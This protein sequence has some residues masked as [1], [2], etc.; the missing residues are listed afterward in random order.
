MIELREISLS[1][2]NRKVLDGFSCGFYKGLNWL[3]G[4]SGSGKSSI[5]KMILGDLKPDKGEVAVPDGLSFA[6]AG[7]DPSLLYD[8]DFQTNLRKFASLS[9]LP[10]RLQRLAKDFDA[11]KLFNTRIYR[12]SG[13]ERK[14]LELL[15]ALAKP[16]DLYIL[17]EPFSSLDRSSK[18]ALAAYLTETKGQRNYL[19]VNHDSDTPLPYDHK[20]AI[21]NGKAEAPAAG[22]P[23]E[24]EV[25]GVKAKVSLWD[26]LRHLLFEARA[27]TALEAVMFLLSLLSLVTCLGFIPPNEDQANRIGLNASPFPMTLFDGNQDEV[28]FE[29][30]MA[31]YDAADLVYLPFMSY[32]AENDYLSELN[33]GLLA[34]DEAPFALFQ[35]ENSQ[36]FHIHPDYSYSKNDEVIAGQFA[37]LTPESPVLARLKDYDYFSFIW[38]GGDQALFL[39]PKSELPYVAASFLNG[40]FHYQD[41]YADGPAIISGPPL[42]LV[43]FG[44]DYGLTAG[45]STFAYTTD[46]S[47]SLIS[48]SAEGLSIRTASNRFVPAEY[49]KDNVMSFGAYAYLSFTGAYMRSPIEGKGFLLLGNGKEYLSSFDLSI[50]RPIGIIDFNES[51]LTEPRLIF[52]SLTP[53]LAGFYFLVFLFSIKNDARNLRSLSLTY[54]RNGIE[55]R[56]AN[57]LSL[58][59][60]VSPLL[61]GLLVSIILYFGLVWPLINYGQFLCDYPEGYGAVYGSAYGNV[62]FLWFYRPSWLLLL[63]VVYLL[64]S[65]LGGLI[66]LRKKR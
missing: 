34:F 18:D 57:R 64:P 51:A 45:P 37:M 55:E 40:D 26:S 2:A 6:Y 43:T 41:Y 30:F 56:K 61:V 24:P 31:A 38:D 29:D 7:P 28:E 8:R 44:V 13:G 33:A 59:A 50:F 32:D 54:R 16:A 60:Y 22:S 42:Q 25:E 12:L 5:I 27:L 46:S 39:C 17:D 66:A 23:I 9:E 52:N 19:V 14:K 4:E 20:V 10:E 53:I 11:V 49:G 3:D 1:F 47:Y 58:T 63:S 48:R 15:V 36:R 62:S 21:A 65:L 35:Q